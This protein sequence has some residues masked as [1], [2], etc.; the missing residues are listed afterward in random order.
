MARRW[1]GEEEGG[2]GVVKRVKVLA[3]CGGRRCEVGGW[4]EG[5][6]GRLKVRVCERVKVRVC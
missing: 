2:G 6:C 5:V 1:V 4:E 3:V